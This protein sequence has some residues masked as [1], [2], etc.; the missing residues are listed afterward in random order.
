VGS[1]ELPVRWRTFLPSSFLRANE[2]E[3][4]PGRAAGWACALA[5]VLAV[6]APCAG[7]GAGAGAAAGDDLEELAWRFRFA[8]GA[9]HASVL[10]EPLQRTLLSMQ[11]H[12][13]ANL[14]QVRTLVPACSCSTACIC[15]L[16]LI[17][18]CYPRSCKR[19]FDD[20][21][22]PGTPGSSGTNCNF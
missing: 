22:R 3:M 9:A 4:P 13:A 7:A 11:E 20:T 19:R 6:L 8:P 10:L 17:S 15:A 2:G 18:A 12:V 5:L 16:P 1:F 21:G 14:A